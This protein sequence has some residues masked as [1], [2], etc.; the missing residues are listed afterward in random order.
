M[1]FWQI[2]LIAV[3]GG[4]VV[5]GIL[6]VAWRARAAARGPGKLR[7]LTPTEGAQNSG[8]PGLSR[9]DMQAIQLQL[10]NLGYD[11][12]VYDGTWAPDDPTWHAVYA[13]QNAHGLVP[14]GKP[15]P[16][17][18]KRL[19]EVASGTPTEPKEPDLPEPGPKAS[20][21][22]YEYFR[23]MEILPEV[24]LRLGESKVYKF[25]APTAEV[26]HKGV[27]AFDPRYPMEGNWNVAR[28]L[29]AIGEDGFLYLGV[30]ATEPGHTIFQVEKHR[31]G[32]PEIKLFAV[33]IHVVLH[34]A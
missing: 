10:A 17:T 22:D 25:P 27:M 31:T 15:G 19:R 5:G 23:D 32:L 3:A 18:R 20:L 14:D 2:A 21:E 12:G 13:F 29:S 24:T 33:P 4:T 11:P 1:P 16:N 34:E 28:H 8:Y 30:Q 7:A 6:A 9:S 26:E